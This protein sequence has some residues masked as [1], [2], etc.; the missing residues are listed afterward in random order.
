[1]M[2]LPRGDDMSIR[3]LVCCFAA[4]FFSCATVQK[5]VIPTTD[6]AVSAVTP[7]KTEPTAASVQSQPATVPDAAG[8][9][10]HDLRDPEPPKATISLPSPFWVFM[11][12]EKMPKGAAAFAVNIGLAPSIDFRKTDEPP[13][14]L[15]NDVAFSLKKNLGTK[16]IISKI[17][18]APDGLTAGF[19]YEVK[20]AKNPA[21][22]KFVAKSYR[23]LSKDSS[24][25]FFGKWPSHF[26]ELMVPEFDATVA[27]VEFQ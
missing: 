21:K 7:D 24:L 6:K 23:Q 13:V 9:S 11:P 5:P 3:L 1:M 4:S 15:A 12:P 17:T 27:G 8:L 25:A 2:F 10:R 19:T 18:T 20:D 16:M 14:K 22:G 26:D